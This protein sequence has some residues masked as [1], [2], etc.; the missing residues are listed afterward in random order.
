VINLQATS[1]RRDYQQALQRHY[2]NGEPSDWLQRYV[3]PYA[4]AHPWED[5]AETWAHYFHVV[6][7]LETATAFGCIEQPVSVH[8]VKSAKTP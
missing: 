5:F 8:R 2:A 1:E 4:S 3:T 6:D 7:T